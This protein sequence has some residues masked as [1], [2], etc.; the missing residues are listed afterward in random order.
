MLSKLVVLSTVKDATFFKTFPSPKVTGVM[1]VFD[2][3]RTL[4]GED[5]GVDGDAVDNSAAAA[6]G[7]NWTSFG[8]KFRFAIENDDRVDDNDSDKPR[9][10]TIYIYNIMSFLCIIFEWVLCTVQ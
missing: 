3:D 7:V 5:G 6:V 9:I 4:W 1:T 10:K 2:C 8:S